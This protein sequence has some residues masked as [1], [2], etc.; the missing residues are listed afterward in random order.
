MATGRRTREGIEPD[1]WAK[2]LAMGSGDP[3]DDDDRLRRDRPRREQDH[4]VLVVGGGQV[5]RRLAERLAATHAVHHLD[6]DPNVVG[7]AKSHA[8]SHSRDL[9]NPAALA[10]TGVTDADAAVVVTGLD[11]RSLLVVQQL[12][13]QL[14]LER[15]LVVLEDP[16]NREAFDLPGVEVVCAGAVLSSAVEEV[17][18][19]DADGAGGDGVMAPDSG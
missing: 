9:A 19:G 4:R 2:R 14:D 18:L 13:T 16:R 7:A 10:A 3:A 17:V 5:G 15:L 8:A 12:R 1:A 6:A 11:S